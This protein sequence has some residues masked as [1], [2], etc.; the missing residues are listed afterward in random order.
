MY[1]RI[2]V[3]VDGSA[4][5]ERAV[6]HAVRLAATTGSTVVFL[7][8]MDTLREFN[9]GVMPEVRRELQAQG[10]AVLDRAQ[11]VAADAGVDAACELLEGSPADVIVEKAK[12]FDL[13]V[14]G[15]HGKG[16]WKRLTV[17]SVTQSV[18]H[19]TPAPLLVVPAAAS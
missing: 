16:L 6:E 14:M 13:V 2:L 18:L 9:E 1:R 10:T 7:F 17:G 3:A 5:G 15:S 4:C 12:N 11:K 19:R 8:V